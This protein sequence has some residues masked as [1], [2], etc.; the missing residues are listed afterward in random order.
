V[1]PDTHVNWR[2]VW[3]GAVITALLFVLGKY[4]VGK[5]LAYASVGS[6]YGAAGS[7]MVMLVWVYYTSLIVFFGVELTQVY[8]PSL[9][10]NEEIEKAEEERREEEKT[11]EDGK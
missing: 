3:L 1:L 4:A 5:Y 6:A 7:L 10:K 9:K 11:S 8:S 2:D